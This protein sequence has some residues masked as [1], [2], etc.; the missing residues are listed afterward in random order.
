[1]DKRLKTGD[2]HLELI[3]EPHRFGSYG[4]NWDHRDENHEV[5]RPADWP[6][7]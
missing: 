2:R 7:Q 4:D 5:Q 6:V 1:M 3:F